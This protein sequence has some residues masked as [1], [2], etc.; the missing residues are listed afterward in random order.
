[1]P[2]PVSGVSMRMVPRAEVD[3]FARNY[4]SVH[5]LAGRY[6]RSHTALLRQLAEL[7]V[8]PV[9]N[10]RVTGIPFF[11]RKLAEPTM[12]QISA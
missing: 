2:H 1:M 7:G 11:D 4:V 5:E 10:R 6:S 9:W 3:A 8:R 12:A